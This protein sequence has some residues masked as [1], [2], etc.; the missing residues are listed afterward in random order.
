MAGDLLPEIA[1]AVERVRRAGREPLA[2]LDV[3][4]TLLD[5]ASRSRGIWSEWLHRVRDRLPGAEEAM[6]RA[7]TMPMVFGVKRNLAWLGVEDPDLVKD[8]VSFWLDAFFSD[9]WCRLDTALPG[10]VDAVLALREADVTV[11][12]LTAR[13]ATMVEGTT[14]RFRELGL[15]VAGPGTS[16]VMKQDR[17]ERDGDFKARALGWIG[18]LGDPVVCADN[19]PGHVNAMLEAFPGALA[20]QVGDRHSGGAPPLAAPARRVQRLIDGIVA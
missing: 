12:Y 1:E 6:V 8:A 14:A 11:V 18:R 3:D 7:Q 2:V 17:S 20:L 4:L 19:E 9:R 16:L 15:P 5:N 13:P 10:A